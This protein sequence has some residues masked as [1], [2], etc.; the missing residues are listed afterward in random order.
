MM[1]NARTPPPMY[2]ALPPFGQWTL[3]GI[4]CTQTPRH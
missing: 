3:E 4:G 1:I 2:I